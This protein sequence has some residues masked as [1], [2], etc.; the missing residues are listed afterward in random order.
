M[1]S[2]RLI[3]LV[4]RDW[5]TIADWVIAQVHRD[6][7]APHYRALS[8]DELRLRARDLLSNLSRWLLDRNDIALAERY[9]LLGRQRFEEG[10]PLHEVIYKLQMLKRAV[11]QYA[12][13]MHLERTALELYEEQEF[14][15][16]LDGFF[17][18][19]VY[20]VARG[21][22]EAQMKAR[23]LAKIA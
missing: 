14:L 19:V 10:F 21:Y 4:E 5:A 15:W 6:P 1:L 3:Q 16:V 2:Q 22:S 18:R 13:D 7:E 9:A 8:D 23:S 11:L 17:D 20:Q 12:R